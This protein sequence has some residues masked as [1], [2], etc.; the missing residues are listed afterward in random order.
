MVSSSVLVC[1]HSRCTHTTLSLPACP[2]HHLISASFAFSSDV[3]FHLPCRCYPILSFIN[4]A[5]Q[6]LLYQL[7][8]LLP[9]HQ[10]LLS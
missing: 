6:R 4:K 1:N 9:M 3:H 7:Y 2:M 10:A 5:T 8:V